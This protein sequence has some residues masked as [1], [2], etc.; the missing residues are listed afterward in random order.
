M[1]HLQAVNTRGY[2]TG[3]LEAT[4]QVVRGLLAIPPAQRF[5]RL[6][7]GLDA[8]LVGALARARCR[9]LQQERRP[10]LSDSFTSRFCRFSFKYVAV[11]LL[12]RVLI[13][14]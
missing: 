4:G 13:V 9:T 1:R 11:L 2:S 10:M 5:D 12:A 6:N 8:P 14:R 7:L 3:R